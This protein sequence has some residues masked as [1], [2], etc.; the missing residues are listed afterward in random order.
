[1]RFDTRRW[2]RRGLV[3]FAGMS[4]FWGCHGRT[5]SLE[6]AKVQRYEERMAAERF[7]AVPE[8]TRIDAPAPVELQ[9]KVATTQP[10]VDAVL[11]LHVPDP[12]MATEAF[13]KRLEVT[14]FSDSV[15]REYEKKIFPKAE[16]YIKQIHRD[17]TFRLTLS[18][19]LRRAL[20]NNYQIHIDSFTP[21]ISTAQAVQAEAAFDTAFFANVN[22]NNTNRPTPSQLL[23]SNTDTTTVS[24]GIRKLLATGAAVTLTQAMTR[25]DNPGFQ[26]N[27]L[28][29]SWVQTFV[30]EI[31]QP[32]LRN[33][34]IDFNRSQI[35]LRV[36]E[37]QSNREAF[38]ATVIDTLNNTERAYWDL[39]AARRDVTISAEL[40]AHAEQTYDQIEARIDF[41]AY[42]TL[43]SRSAANVSQ[44]QFNYLSVKN[45]VRNA[46]DQLLNLLNDP[47]LPL[48]ADIEVIPVD[49]PITTPLVRDR[50]HEV[51]IALERRPELVQARRGVDIARLQLGI[52]K[53][54]ALP[55]VDVTYRATFNG[56]GANADRSF[57]QQTGANFVDQF[58]GVQIAWNF[59]ERAERAGIRI[60]TLQQSQAVAAYKRALDDVITDCR[61]ALR[62]LDTSLEQIRPSR[63][64][65]ASS[66]DNLRAQQERQERKSPA[67]LDS[68]LNSQTSLAQS[69]RALLQAVVA[70]NQGIVDVERA[71]GTLLEYNNVVLTERP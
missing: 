19:A 22:R 55:Q 71:K 28:N 51:Q 53:N 45:R 52:A 23:A 62:N 60:A 10:A 30:A 7:E 44:Q 34:G 14:R 29:P 63:D 33:F 21:A 57:D 58:V 68:V 67:D 5:V 11:W 39:V 9:G 70:Y 27:T 26:F 49:N 15:R 12:S 24:G 13:A 2:L 65:V 37:Q 35:T 3:G 17:K 56:L 54:Q 18:D 47:E 41:D 6:E 46:E 31:R 36:L 50:F 69:R 40:L 64:A 59:G 38:R 48:S 1:M 8:P 42:I 4:F 32:I 43:L 20:A 25:I 61:V 16:R 66:F